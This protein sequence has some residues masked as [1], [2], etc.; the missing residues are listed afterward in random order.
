MAYHNGQ[1]SHVTDAQAMLSTYPVGRG[2]SRS[3]VQHRAL[4][5]VAKCPGVAN[6]TG[7]TAQS[8]GGGEWVVFTLAGEVMEILQQGPVSD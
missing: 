2:Q 4:G 6:K 8:C 1:H 5:H 7:S 3:P